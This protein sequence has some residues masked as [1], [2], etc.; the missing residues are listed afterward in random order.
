MTVPLKYAAKSNMRVLAEST[1]PDFEFNYV[2][3]GSVSSDGVVTRADSLITFADSP[4]RARRLA[5][6]G[7]TLVST[8]RT[9]L[10]AIAFVDESLAADSVFSTG[11]AVLEPTDEFDPRYFNYA[12][13]SEPFVGEVVARSVGV[14]YPAIAPSDLG[15]IPI[16]V[17][18]INVQR[19]IADFLDDQV[20]RIDEVVRLRYEQIE[21]LKQHETV[22]LRDLLAGVCSDATDGDSAIWWLGPVEARWDVVRL[23]QVSEIYGGTSFP[24]EY[25]GRT[26]GHYPF[27]KVA[28]FA[29]ADEAMR[30]GDAE[31]WV[32]TSAARA[33]GA[34][35]LPAD[36][37]VFARVGA[38]LLLNQRRLLTHEA[39][40]DDN[41]RGLKF[42]GE[43]AYLLHLMRLLDFGKIAN[44]GPVPTVS[45]TQ[46]RSIE[47]PFPPIREQSR[48]G[49]RADDLTVSTGNAASEMQAQIALLQ[50][51]KRALITAAMTGEFDVVA[52][53]GRSL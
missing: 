41:V 4:S 11:F 31:N 46:V 52:A 5:T 7:A 20:A 21:T 10:R 47:V 35:V 22:A 48:I 23:G 24:H 33:L 18:P 34:R 12:C 2:D 8:V 38:A 15:E 40:V 28:D 6:P 36:A 27:I 1:S 32:D 50:E 16:P 30:L 9:Y 14:S 25:Q 42:V 37:V 13:R 17:P 3:I 39:I 26:T 49:R 53:S 19:R 45:G 51:R 43:S 44:P 29:R